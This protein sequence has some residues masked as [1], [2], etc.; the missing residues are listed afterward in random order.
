MR[1]DGRWEEVKPG[2]FQLAGHRTN[3]LV[4]AID[5]ARHSGGTWVE[6]WAFNLIVMDTNRMQ[7]LFSRQVNN[8][9]LPTSRTDATFAVLGYGEL[10]REQ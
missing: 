4:A 2:R 10:T 8:M 3:A 5:S 6:S 1:Q 9:Q 7:V